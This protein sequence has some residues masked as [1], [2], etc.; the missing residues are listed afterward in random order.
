MAPP[1][2]TWRVLGLSVAAGYTSL[3]LFAVCLPQRA[4]LEYFAVPPR[5]RAE[6]QKPHGPTR[7]RVASTADAV[8]L[9]MP[10]LGA[11]DLSIGAA[12]WALAYMERWREFGTV[13]VA[14]TVLCLADGVAISRYAGWDRGSLIT[15][16]AMGW[17]G[18]G[19]V[20]LTQ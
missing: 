15:V 5:P 20:L 14:G 2:S 8:D 4:A 13:V 16:S 6:A 9:L 17:T 3:G 11:R 18:I 1:S 10:L 12:L 19:I 7:A